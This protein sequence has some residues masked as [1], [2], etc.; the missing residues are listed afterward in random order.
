[1]SVLRWVAVAALVTGSLVYL[2]AVLAALP[3]W[4]VAA[5]GFLW[6]L[7]LVR[8]VVGGGRGGPAGLHRESADV[9]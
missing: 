6:G 7:V 9:Q 1:M 3:V 8:L 5:A 4:A 2:G